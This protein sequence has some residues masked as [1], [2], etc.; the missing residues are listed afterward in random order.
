M[1]WKWAVLYTALTG[2]TV[3]FV[4]RFPCRRIA[5]A[6]L[7]NVLFTNAF[8]LIVP[9]QGTPAINTIGETFI[10]CAAAVSLIDSPKS[11]LIVLVLSLTSCLISLAYSMHANL[12]ILH[13][14]E[15]LNNAIL[16]AQC[17]VLLPM[18]LWCVV[19]DSVRR[20]SRWRALRRPALDAHRRVGLAPFRRR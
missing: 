9:S 3:L 14:Y 16:I 1:D 13:A 18:G 5:I 7:L 10:I 4:W 12:E 2:V 15:E 20:F 19:G 11:A 17:F 6:F 8:G